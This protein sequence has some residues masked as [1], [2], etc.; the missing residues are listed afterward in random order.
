MEQ[1]TLKNLSNCLNTNI[2]SFLDTS[3]VKILIYI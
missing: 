1:H 3:V 2:Y